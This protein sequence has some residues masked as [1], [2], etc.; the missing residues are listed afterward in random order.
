[1]SAVDVSGLNHISFTVSDLDRSVDFFETACGFEVLSR[2]PRDS[3]VAERVTGVKGADIVVAFLRGPGVVMELIE[4]VGPADRGAVM[5]RPCDVGFAHL[6]LNVGDFD[7]ALARARGYGLTPMGDVCA[8]DRGPNK[9]RQIC[10]LRTW[11]SITLEF[12]EDTPD[13]EPGAGAKS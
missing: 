8:V 9:G 6:A 4:Y 1:M 5:S 3:A 12:I 7:A 11:D 2:G 10:Y 13:A